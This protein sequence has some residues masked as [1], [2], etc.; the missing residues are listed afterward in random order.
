MDDNI[1]KQPTLR[2]L[3]LNIRGLENKL[4]HLVNLIAKYKPDIVTLQETN[5]HSNYSRQAIET[6][7]KVH[8]TIFN[9]AL[10]QHSG[11]TILQTSD[12]WELTQ[13]QTPIGGR[14]IIAKIK[15]GNTEYNLVTIHAPA[16]PHH[17][18]MFFEELANK[19]YPLTDR[20]R[21]LI[22]G[23]FNITL[24]DKDI[25][26]HTGVER[27]GRK[28]LKEVVDSLALQDAFRIIHPAR[29]DTTFT[30]TG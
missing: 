8:N 3:S 20:C 22:I 11:T 10:N 7:L 24:D 5:V 6:K 23:D 12:T 15:N 17:R 1:E 9:F 13:G 28:E 4:H 29:I 26:G 14:E 2:I 30:N 25:V 27:V 19:L 21:T 16:E 18:P